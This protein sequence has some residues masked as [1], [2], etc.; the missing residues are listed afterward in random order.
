MNIQ[1]E[2]S[3][4]III[5]P[6]R[7]SWVTEFIEIGTSL[8]KVL[9]SSVLRID[10]IGSTSVP[11]LAAKDVID[12]QITVANLD[13]D[14]F[15]KKLTDAGYLISS[16]LVY[17]NIVGLAEKDHHLHKLFCREKAGMRRTHIHI[18]E[19]GRT[20]QLYPL[21]F[22]DFLRSSSATRTAYEILKI[23]LSNL[24]PESLDGYLFIKDPLMDIIFQAAQQ[25]ATTSNWAMDDLYL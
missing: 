21:L 22:R 4:P 15:K 13:A 9:T 19:I 8:K 7:Q 20:N 1:F 10:H 5:I 18:R 25:W 2:K 17:D 23:R 6:Y 11:N 12:I 14:D 24:F 16:E 3:R